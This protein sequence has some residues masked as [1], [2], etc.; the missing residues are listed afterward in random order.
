MRETIAHSL[1]PPLSMVDPRT[2]VGTIRIWANPKGAKWIIK[3]IQLWPKPHGLL[4]Q[5]LTTNKRTGY[6][7]R[8][9]G[10]CVV[11]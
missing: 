10:C 6:G 9:E 8:E 7:A 2:D 5:C 11:R 3:E 4:L 1:N